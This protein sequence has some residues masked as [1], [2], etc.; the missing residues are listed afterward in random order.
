[1]GAAIGERRGHLQCVGVLVLNYRTVDLPLGGG[2]DDKTHRH[3]LNAP[4]VSGLL[5]MRLFETGAYTRRPSYSV[6][7]GP[8]GGNVNALAD[9]DGTAVAL[10]TTGAFRRVEGTWRCMRTEGPRPIEVKR[11]PIVRSDEGCNDVFGAAGDGLLASVWNRDLANDSDVW[12]QIADADTGALVYGPVKTGLDGSVSA[13]NS[14]LDCFPL[15]DSGGNL[16]FVVLGKKPGVTYPS[17]VAYQVTAGVVSSAVTTDFTSPASMLASVAHVAALDG[18][19]QAYMLTHD[20]STHIVARLQISGTACVVESTRTATGMGSALTTRGLYI[21]PVGGIVQVFGVNGTDLYACVVAYD[22]TLSGTVAAVLFRAQPLNVP[23]N[24]DTPDMV[25]VGVARDDGTAV[26]AF[27]SQSWYGTGP[28]YTAGTA[29]DSRCVQWVEVDSAGLMVADLNRVIW[30]AHLVARPFF[31]DSRVHI[32]LCAPFLLDGSSPPNPGSSDPVI[33]SN[34][35]WVNRRGAYLLEVASASDETGRRSA[36]CLIDVARRPGFVTQVMTFVGRVPRVSLVETGSTRYAWAAPT[37]VLDFEIAAAFAIDH[38]ADFVELDMNAPAAGVAY[39]NGA[40][41]FGGGYLSQV[42]GERHAEVMQ[43]PPPAVIGA[44]FDTVG[45][46]F[47]GSLSFRFCWTWRDK[48]GN[49]HR[50]APS[51]PVVMDLGDP[52]RAG[53]VDTAADLTVRIAIPPFFDNAADDGTHPT[54]VALECYRSPGAIA[55]GATSAAIDNEFIR[56][57]NFSNGTVAGK[58]LTLAD[59]LDVQKPWQTVDLTCDGVSVATGLPLYTNGGAVPNDPAPSPLDVVSSRD[60]VWLIDSED[61][62][63]ALYSAPIIKGSAP[64]FSQEFFVRLPTEAGELVALGVIGDALVLLSAESVHMLETIGGP[65]R[66]GTVG[67][68]PPVREI[69]RE[70]G[71]INRQSVVSTDVGLFFQ[72]SKGIYLIDASGGLTHVGRDIQPTIEGRTIVGACALSD[73]HQVTFDF[74]DGASVVFD[75]E[76]AAWSRYS[77]APSALVAS[78]K[79][80]G[81]H[82]VTTA[83]DAHAA[84][85]LNDAEDVAQSVTTAWIKLAGLQGYQRIRRVGLLGHIEVP[86]YTPGADVI[87]LGKVVVTM[88]RNNVES[89]DSITYEVE[90]RD[91]EL[92]GQL[93]PLHHIMRLPLS[94]QKSQSLKIGIGYAPPSYVGQGQETVTHQPAKLSI[95]GLAL[96]VGRRKGM[97]KIAHTSGVTPS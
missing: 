25:V 32:P 13:D 88:L 44:R 10:T 57:G 51:D 94:W 37:D 38:T 81:V 73:E 61:R 43:C 28:S 5:N 54:D 18:D 87:D 93:D 26:V 40:A 97:R 27:E 56:L 31:Y 15:R 60:R 96:E 82:W 55:A 47:S 79:I 83:A 69:S 59:V 22:A 67:T 35:P 90:V 80:D 52:A 74:S 21:N 63:R 34:D 30:N 36:E 6:V 86:A 77:H 75:T 11:T 66:T 72:S 8:G 46:A 4:K 84:D 58:R 91:L 53:S 1:M 39:A 16:F 92:A 12:F 48:L 19:D 24:V 89:G 29:S 33:A 2:Q 78:A 9:M 49:A 3:L 7:T 68:F 42:D 64:T 20:G 45:G 65:D 70:V 23:P 76:S 17:A 14:G 50:S 62:Y 95:S 71:C 85:D 41:L